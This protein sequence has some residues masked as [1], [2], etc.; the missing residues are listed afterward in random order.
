MSKNITFTKN[1]L[2]NTISVPQWK[3][4]TRMFNTKEVDLNHELSAARWDDQTGTV[5]YDN[6]TATVGQI[7]AFEMVPDEDK[8]GE[9]RRNYLVLPELNRVDAGTLMQYLINQPTKGSQNSPVQNGQAKPNKGGFG[10]AA[11]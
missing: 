9:M 2:E 5:V 3:N 10:G 7:M 11:K 4:I 6:G 1:S 8:P